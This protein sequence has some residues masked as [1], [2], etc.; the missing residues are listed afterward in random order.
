MLLDLRYLFHEARP[1][2]VTTDVSSMDVI[3]RMKEM[4]LSRLD[5]FFGNRTPGSVGKYDN[6]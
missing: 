3:R 1:F 6:S 5:A 4:I 2:G